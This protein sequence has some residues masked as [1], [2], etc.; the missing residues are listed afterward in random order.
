MSTGCGRRRPAAGACLVVAAILAGASC[1]GEHGR[2]P[3]VRRSPELAGGP[4][5][6]SGFVFI[7]DFG[8][9]EQIEYDVSSTIESWVSDRPFH[10]LLTL[11]DNVYP[12]GSPSDFDAAWR[13]PFAWLLGSGVPVIASLGNHDV[14]TQAG[15]PV[16]ALFDMPGR[17]YERRIG[18]VDFFV[19][20]ANDMSQ[21]GQM[22][23]LSQALSASTAP[24]Q[25]LLFHQPAYS[26]AKHGSDDQVQEALFPVIAGEGVDL[27]VNGHDHDY[28]RFAPVD[29]TTYVVSGGAAASLYDVGDCPDGTPEPVAWNDD[30]QQFLYV[31]A[32]D[33]RLVGISVSVTGRVLDT[34]DLTAAG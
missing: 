24:W 1:I 21:D 26:C 28:Q 20:D 32:T 23:W 3:G 16:M 25:V 19:L 34:F 33:S 7:G 15:A 4:A 14:H 8:N 11:G 9:G 22:A 29:G 30:V 12:D 18:P 31:S 27:V 5:R 6:A 13:K 10:A 17:W 2:D